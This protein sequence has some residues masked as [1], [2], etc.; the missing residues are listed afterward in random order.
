MTALRTMSDKEI[1]RFEVLQ[2]VIDRHMTQQQAGQVLGLNRRQV[3]RLL[4]AVKQYG[5]ARLIS[6]RRGTRSNYQL[7]SGLTLPSLRQQTRW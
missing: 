6:K 4:K 3:Y 2:R 7:A 1:S 5:A